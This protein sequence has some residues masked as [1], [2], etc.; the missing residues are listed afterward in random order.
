MR[1]SLDQL[2]SDSHKRRTLPVCH[3]ALTAGN[4]PSWGSGEHSQAL[5][6]YEKQEHFPIIYTYR[7][8]KNA[9]ATQ[10]FIDNGYHTKTDSWLRF[11]LL[12][13]EAN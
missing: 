9:K 3:S 8:K 1:C 5:P 12:L 10:T 7:L 2:S 13:K 6:V 4:W 11:H